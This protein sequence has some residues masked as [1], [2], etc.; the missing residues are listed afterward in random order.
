MGANPMMTE[1]T[2][3]LQWADYVHICK[4]ENKKFINSIG[5]LKSVRE[6][7]HKIR[8]QKNKGNMYAGTP[9]DIL[10][11]MGNQKTMHRVT[12]R[13]KFLYKFGWDDRK[14][15]AKRFNSYVRCMIN[16]GALTIDTSGGTP[17]ALLVRTHNQ[18]PAPRPWA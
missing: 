13:D 7:S 15:C 8:N 3:M 14:L 12:L 4:A 10:D 6:V 11:L 17:K 5:G 1:D 9:N 2:V 16:N 18:L